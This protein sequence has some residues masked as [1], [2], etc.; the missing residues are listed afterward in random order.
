ML[1]VRFQS[2]NGRDVR[3][4]FALAP[5]TGLL[6][7]YVLDG[8]SIIEQRGGLRCVAPSY[9]QATPAQDP[10]IV[11]SLHPFYQFIQ[12][13]AQA[14]DATGYDFSDGHTHTIIDMPDDGAIKFDDYR[15]FVV[16][17][18]SG[19][20]AGF[21]IVGF[22]IQSPNGPLACPTLIVPPLADPRCERLKE[23]AYALWCEALPF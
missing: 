15:D 22:A 16:R 6:A 2:G 21:D 19:P 7:G 3:A 9:L 8:F 14:A 11:R 1:K 17:M 4:R 12:A 5:S 13:Y 10:R 18:T 20:L 23:A